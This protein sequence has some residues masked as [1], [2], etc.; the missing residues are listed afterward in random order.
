MKRII[1][2]VFGWLLLTVLQTYAAE[3]E[4][5][6]VTIPPAVSSKSPSSSA[7]Y[8]HFTV[9]LSPSSSAESGHIKVTK[10]LLLE[11]GVATVPS[12]IIQTKEGG[13]VVAGKIAGQIAW[14]TMVDSKGN[15]QWRY[16]GPQSSSNFEG[17]ATMR[18]DS[19]LLCGW[20]SVHEPSG[21][22]NI[23]GVLTHIDKAGKV[24]SEHVLRPQEPGEF[25]NSYIKRC[26]P[27]GE[28]F[29]LIGITNR[30]SG[31]SQ[32]SRKIETLNWISALD[33]AGNVKWAK[34]IPTVAYIYPSTVYVANDQSLD[35]GSIQVSESGE[36]RKIKSL[37]ETPF[38]KAIPQIIVEPDG[39]WKVGQRI[40][41]PPTID[42]IS[43]TVIFSLPDTS[44]VEFGL[45][46]RNGSHAAVEWQG[47]NRVQREII[48][49]GDVYGVNDAIPTGNPGEFV[50]IRQQ[51]SKENETGMLLSFIQIKFQ[52]KPI[53]LA[54]GQITSSMTPVD[55][56]Q[57]LT[58]C[59][60]KD[61][62]ETALLVYDLASVYE[63]YDSKRVQALKSVQENFLF[64][65]LISMPPEKRI[66]FNN[67]RNDMNGTKYRGDSLCEKIEKIGAPVYYPSYMI[68]RSNLEVSSNSTIPSISNLNPS[69]DSKA[70]WQ[71]AKLDALN[72]K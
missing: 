66:K 59:I 26:L 64:G 2:V 7:A 33:E 38:V 22:S 28:G 43:N 39:H 31:H 6:T 25:S 56:S 68:Q 65:A 71:Q 17:V 46:S 8:D 3:N 1:W 9:T 4:V 13:Y 23:V 44:Q 30:V 53:C 10:E 36:I 45:L 41:A 52:Q 48:E 16:Q 34:L 32:A 20:K 63:Q 11:S 62:Y 12:T 29:A 54:P 72:C 69:F 50:T 24:L 27:W 5:V 70:A 67:Q 42:Y 55:L 37:N 58:A 19:F 21:I 51:N 61:D 47:P 35:M 14:A 60:N 40:V 49:L 57:A 15:M 18:D